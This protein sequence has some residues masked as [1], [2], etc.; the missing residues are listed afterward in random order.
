[1]SIGPKIARWALLF[2]VALPARP[3]TNS[4]PA[5]AAPT[6]ATPLRL[7]GVNL[8]GTPVEPFAGHPYSADQTAERT[9]TLADG[10]HITEI[11]QKTTLYRD[12]AGRVRSEHYFAAPG[13]DP[14]SVPT[15][16]EIVDPVAGYRYSLDPN[17]HTAHRSAWPLTRHGNPQTPPS[18]SGV[19]TA[20]PSSA[21]PALSPG[22]AKAI[23]G[24]VPGISL[25]PVSPSAAQSE[26]KQ[27]SLGT[28]T[29]EGIQAEG[30]RLTTTYPQGSIG[31][32]RPITTVSEHWVSRDLNMVI[33]VKRSDPRTGETITK[34]SNISLSDPDPSL[35]EVPPD[36]S[37]ADQ[38]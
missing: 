38:Q 32:D 18:R 15:F 5:P 3:Q 10:T 8:Y 33:L 1:M 31:N 23:S 6:S 14:P 35:F 22:L 25:T 9:Q 27:E 13:A 37:I 28:Q 36:Y 24:A 20:A 7:A 4:A 2:A 26:S 17:T 19:T 21:Q 11:L 29:I 34:L 12:S 16:I 30:I